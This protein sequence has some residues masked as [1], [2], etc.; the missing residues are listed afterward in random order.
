MQQEIHFCALPSGGRLAYAVA[1]LGR[2]LLIVPGWVSHLDLSWQRLESSLSGL[3]SHFRI[4]RYDKRGTGLSDRYTEDL[5]ASARLDDLEA[6]IGHLRLDRLSVF[7]SSSGGLTAMS[8]AAA[9]PGQVEKLVLYG[10]FARGEAVAGRRQTSGALASLVRAE[11]GLASTALTDLFMPGA[12]TAE[13]TAYAAN[14]TAAADAA[15]A[16]RLIEAIVEEDVTGLLP[17]I[18]AETL[19]I[20]TKGDRAVPFEYGR[21]VAAAIPNARLLALEGER[22]VLTPEGEAALWQQVALFLHSGEPSEA[23]VASAVS[24]PADN[25]DG[26]SPRE[27]E[28]LQLIAAGLSNRQ[29]AEA[30]VVSLN[31]VAHH[32]RNI[33]VKAGLHN[34]AEA[35]SYAYLHD[36]TAGRTTLK[37]A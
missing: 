4:Y 8:F 33:F 13:R 18:T 35:A 19:V 10:P 5:S 9:H 15:V 2:P 37:T 29:I 12:S 28:V 36:M 11:W 27:I 14:Q 22:H 34:R 7:A 31:T 16:A 32:V 26:L 17:Q 25:P 30:L 23:V 21:E 3:A 1:G 6:L 24:G 20:H